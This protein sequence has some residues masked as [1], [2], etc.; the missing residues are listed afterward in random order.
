VHHDVGSFL[1]TF[2]LFRMQAGVCELNQFLNNI[3]KTIVEALRGDGSCKLQVHK[4]HCLAL[5]LD[6][7]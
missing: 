6:G 5:L 2:N 4:E 3:A 1:S 7:P